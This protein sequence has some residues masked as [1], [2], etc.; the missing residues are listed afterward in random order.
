[1][2][3]DPPSARYLY[4]RTRRGEGGLHT[5]KI[6]AGASVLKPQATILGVYYLGNRKCLIEIGLVRVLRGVLMRI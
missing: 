4:E 6:R 1:M 3:A 2:G 5:E